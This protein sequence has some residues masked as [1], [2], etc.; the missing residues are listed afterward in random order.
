MPYITSPYIYLGLKQHN[1]DKNNT[2][3]DEKIPITSENKL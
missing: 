1:S 3:T 2:Y